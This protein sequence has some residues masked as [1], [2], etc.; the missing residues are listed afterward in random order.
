MDG[1]GTLA[2]P[3]IK[4]AMKPNIIT[5]ELIMRDITGHI[6]G[7]ALCLIF[8]I[9]AGATLYH[10]YTVNTDPVVQSVTADVMAGK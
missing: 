1:F 7:A 6:L 4:L 8:A 9:L 10:S 3:S 2:G 5:E